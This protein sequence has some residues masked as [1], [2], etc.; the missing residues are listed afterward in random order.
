MAHTLT[1]EYG[2]ELL[3]GLGLSP[4]EFASEA[5][6]LLA[7]KLYELGRLTSG[8]AAALCGKSRVDPAGVHR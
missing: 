5:K 6:L 3:L 1:I 8:Q 4:S 7:A 2:D